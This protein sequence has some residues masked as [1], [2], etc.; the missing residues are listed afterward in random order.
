[1]SGLDRYDMARALNIAFGEPRNLNEELR[2]ILDRLPDGSGRSGVGLDGLDAPG[3]DPS[4]DEAPLSISFAYVQALITPA[5]LKAARN[6]P[7]SG[8]QTA[9]NTG[10]SRA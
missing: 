2:S 1:M 4:N 10:G 6:A 5:E 9:E 3:S 8:V 7:G